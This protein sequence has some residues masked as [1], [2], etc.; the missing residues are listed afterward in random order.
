MKTTADFLDDLRAKLGATSDGKLALALKLDRQQVSR[1]RQQKNAF[2]DDTT[3]KIAAQL[4]IEPDY[5][6][7]CMAVQRARTP[8]ART[9]WERIAAKVAAC[10]V[11]GIALQTPSPAPAA[12]LQNLSGGTE[13]P[14]QAENIHMQQT[15]RRRREW[16]ESLRKRAQAAFSG[17]VR[18][19]GLTLAL[20]GCASGAPW[21]GADIAREAG[22][23]A[24][25]TVDCAQ[26]RYGQSR[27]DQF[28]EGNPLLPEHPSKGRINFTCAATGFGHWAISNWLASRARYAWQGITIGVE[29]WAIDFNRMAGVKLEF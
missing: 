23:Q 27:P 11:L 6:M 19:L 28:R 10:F 1:W 21:T 4:G 12:I 13:R 14:V 24:A 9:A 15:R 3:L 16:L 26:T 5:I 25:L 22:Y 20:A 17:L 18:A 8:E 7:A 29:L 2:D